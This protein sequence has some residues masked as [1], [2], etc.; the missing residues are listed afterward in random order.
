MCVAVVLGAVVGLV[1]TDTAVSVPVGP[2]VPVGPT[3]AVMLDVTGGIAVSG[4]VPDVILDGLG[5]T[6]F[7]RVAVDS[8]VA[9]GE[10]PGEGSWLEHPARQSAATINPIS[11]TPCSACI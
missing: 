11:I 5:L 10:T 7:A 6:V 4:A 1:T 8:N 2:A 9:E 3:V